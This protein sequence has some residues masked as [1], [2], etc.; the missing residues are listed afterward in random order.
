MAQGLDYVH[1]PS[2]ADLKAAG[3]SFVCRYLSE[4][5]PAT[6]VKLLTPAEAQALSATGIG[7]VSNFE[8]Y[9]ARATEG[10]T[11]GAQ[12]AQLAAQQHAA[13]GGPASRPIYFS[14]DADV[15]GT[16]VADYFRGVASVIGLSRTGAYGSY[17]VIKYLF[18][19]HLIA[20]G[21][22]TYAWSAGQ[23]EPR[24]HIQQYENNVTIAGASVDRDRSMQ[25]DFGQWFA[26]GTTVVKLSSTGEIA[27]FLDVDQFQPAKT[28]FACGYFSG[29]IIKAMAQVGQPPTQSVPQMIAEAESWYA[30]DHGNNAISN[31]SGM[32]LQE[33]YNLITQRMELHYQAVALDAATVR[34]WV[35]AGYPIML[36]I[37]EASV[38]DMALGRNPY[39]WNPSGTHIIVVSG[40]AGDGN[41]LVRDPA[42]CT[43]LYDPNSLRPGPRK[44]DASKLQIWTATVVVPS[45][46]PRPTSAIPPTQGDTS[47]PIPAGWSDNGTTLTA[48]NKVPV[49]AGF[50]QHILNAASWNSGNVPQEAEYHADQVLLHNAAVGAG[51]RQLFR[52]TLLWYTPAKNVV[53]E[54]YMGL[55]LDAAYKQIAALQAQLAAQQQPAPAP[56][57]VDTTQVEADINAIADAI[58]VPV[59]KALA[60]L[61]KL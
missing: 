61:K 48:S 18:D 21:W 7:I 4:V 13:C 11:A 3:I 52:D 24:A 45:W 9:A 59:A 36:T 57:P 34:G 12:D 19:N 10:H 6:Q 40:V 35:R 56:A 42:N 49:V 5:N 32:S 58:A 47:M 44:Y 53:E 17:Q 1:G 16:A 20:W 15:D 41:L 28:Q 25:A 14:V 2:T 51:Q 55:E 60:D 37:S 22:Q 27:D 33:E 46:L 23:W 30:A 54:P 26:G 38:V 43:N 31:T 8:W 29:A 50:R 39:P